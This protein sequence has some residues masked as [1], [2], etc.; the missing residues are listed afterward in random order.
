MYMKF[1]TVFGHTVTLPSAITA[2]LGFVLGLAL[3]FMGKAMH[4]PALLLAL[5]FFVAAY[6]MNCAVVGKCE[7]WAWT[8]FA[9]YALVAAVTGARMYKAF[10]KRASGFKASTPEEVVGLLKRI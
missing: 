7:A 1:I 8:L 5:T 2:A 6:N 3:S 9:L 4:V 10:G